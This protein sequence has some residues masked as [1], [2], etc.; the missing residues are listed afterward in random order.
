MCFP[1]ANLLRDLWK[2]NFLDKEILFKAKRN[3]AA[4]VSVY[5]GKGLDAM[6]QRKFHLK[7]EEMGIS[8]GTEYQTKGW[9]KKDS[10]WGRQCL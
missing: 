4:F 3:V 7:V 10:D 2:G 1:K 8:R 5:F 6:A 9:L